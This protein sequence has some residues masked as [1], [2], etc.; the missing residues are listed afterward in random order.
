L[1]PQAPLNAIKLRA[2]TQVC[3]YNP[4]A[5][6]KAVGANLRVRPF[7]I[8]YDYNTTQYR[9]STML[10]KLFKSLSVANIAKPVAKSVDMV[11][12]QLAEKP[13]F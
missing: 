1:E 5:Y 9:Y 8:L 10:S 13:Q 4:P 7:E 12:I 11:C 6:L 3:P 2:D